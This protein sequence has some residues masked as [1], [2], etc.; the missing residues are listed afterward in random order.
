LLTVAEIRNSAKP[1][2]RDGDGLWLH[3]SAA[4][5]RYWVFIYIRSSRRR[6]MGLGAYG[7]GTGQVSLAA[8]REKA[9]EIRGILGR[10]GDPFTEMKERQKP[11]RALTFGDCADEYIDTMKENWRGAKT[12]AAW[13]NML[14]VHAKPLRRL[15][16]GEISSDDVAR[17]LKPIWNV[18]AETATK[19]RERVKLVL[20]YAK[21]RGLR[22]GENPAEWKGNLQQILAA[23][24]TL[25]RGHH[26]AMPYADLP[27]FVA[28]L[29]AAGTVSAAALEFLILTAA[30]SGEARGAVVS[31]INLEDK[32][33]IVPA[34]RM[35]EHREHRVPLS[36]RAE[37]IARNRVDLT[38]GDYLFPGQRSGRPLT[39][40]G[41]ASVFK[42]LDVDGVTIHGFRSSFRDWVSEETEFE[43]EIAEAALAH[44][45]GDAVERAYR[46]GDV[47]AKRRKLM[48]AWYDFLYPAVEEARG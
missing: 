15:L 31:E 42:T 4:G 34:S 10:G 39:D 22:S 16:V 7:S 41:L 23:P 26:A 38:P 5:N 14:S 8:A 48:E 40:M 37:E 6:E 9:D 35:K 28:R 20:D 24:K 19:T 11:A 21:A 2:L 43:G 25:Q 30:R 47:L 32:I 45:T 27:A 18:K 3:T 46:R 17:C 33:W 13:R 29:R 12:E 44:A 36:P 1:K